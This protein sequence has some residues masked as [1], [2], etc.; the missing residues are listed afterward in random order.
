MSAAGLCVIILRPL[1]HFLRQDA[2][3]ALS[4]LADGGARALRPTGPTSP[5]VA[6]VAALWELMRWPETRSH[7]TAVVEQA[8]QV[9]ELVHADV[10]TG[11]DAR[12]AALRRTAGMSF[13]MAWA[14]VSLFVLILLPLIILLPS[15][16]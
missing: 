10:A 1:L 4:A 3:E 16:F 11:E 6:L 9:H 13:A 12:M 7:L 15:E 5:A 8:L 2:H 14:Q